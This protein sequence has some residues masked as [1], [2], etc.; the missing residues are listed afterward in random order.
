MVS[1]GWDTVFATSA[2][3]AL[4]LAVQ[5]EFDAIVTDLRMPGMSG[6][7]LL[8]ELSKSEST[9]AVPVVIVT[10]AGDRELTR[11]ALK[12]GAADLIS[13]PFPIE[14]LLARLSSVLKIK[15]Y[16]D[17]LKALNHT[18][19]QRVRDRTSEL[20]QSR[21]DAI[22]YMAWS[23][24]LHDKNTGH[25]LL[26]VAQYSRILSEEIC[27]PPDFTEL[28]FLTSLLHDIGKISIPGYILLKEG[29]LTDEERRIM[30]QHCAI[31][32]RIL[33]EPPDTHWLYDNHESAQT[34]SDVQPSANNK[35]LELAS[36][37]A[38]SHHECW[39]GTG[40]PRRLSADDI[41]LEARI[42]AIADVYD[43][44]STARPYKS[45]FPDDVVN[46]IILNS[47]GNQFDPAL[48]QAFF[49][50]LSR[51]RSVRDEF[52]DDARQ[53]AAGYAK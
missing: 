43:A 30:Q 32:A 2:E 47:S 14:D 11:Q 25:H 39:N 24:E 48:T 1:P 42:V 35:F 21:I 34:S 40:Y 52:A 49:S 5:T 50:S 53:V 46:D 9:R 17:E 36:S 33:S 10:G 7:D 44:L 16:Q 20:E 26:R 19:E 31:G 13:K 27:A 12:L 28:I 38:M 15:S 22:W 51:M 3:E 18:L 29:K 4:Q 6:L 8:H 37:I 41:P 45:A 23:A